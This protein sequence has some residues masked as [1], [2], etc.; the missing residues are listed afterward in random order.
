MNEKKNISEAY[1]LVG[2]NIVASAY[3]EKHRIQNMYI[4][5]DDGKIEYVA[6]IPSQVNDE[7]NKFYED[8]ECL[9]NK[10]LSFS[11]VFYFASVIHL[12]FVKIHPWND[13]NGRS[14]RLLE[15]WFI[16]GKIRRK[17]LV[18]SK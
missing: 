3:K 12:I 9:S 11:E 1:K 7:M 16:S 10:E 17:S 14:A 6:T 4:T 8:L 2:R 18:S 5:T 15:K 13:G